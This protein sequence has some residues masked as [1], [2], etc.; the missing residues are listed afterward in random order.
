LIINNIDRRITVAILQTGTVALFDAEMILI[1]LDR[2]NDNLPRNDKGFEI[3]AL[4]IYLARLIEYQHITPD[5][6]SQ[7]SGI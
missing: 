4:L 3:L 1:A 5:I 2:Q 7:E 6:Q